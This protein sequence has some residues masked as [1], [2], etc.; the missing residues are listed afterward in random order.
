MASFTAVFI[1]CSEKQMKP[2]A[3]LIIGELRDVKSKCIVRFRTGYPWLELHERWSDGLKTASRLSRQHNTNTIYL[4]AQ[5]VVD[6]HHYAHF[7]GGVRK[8]ELKYCPES[9]GWLTALGK[10]EAW[11]PEELFAGQSEA[12]ED[13]R[14]QFSETS[15][16]GERNRLEGEV[17]AF[18]G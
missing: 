15:D 6:D 7:V 12:L 9:G 11:E 8:R 14:Q 5:T 13:L 16:P 18:E 4:D 17:A 2:F 1:K 10:P 3:E